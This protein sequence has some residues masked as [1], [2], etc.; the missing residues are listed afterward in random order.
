MIT[1]KQHENDAV[2]L[3]ERKNDSHEAILLSPNDAFTDDLIEVKKEDK[4]N[5]CHFK[6][7]VFVFHID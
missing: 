3:T 7:I 6:C 2:D 1:S 4:F 5:A